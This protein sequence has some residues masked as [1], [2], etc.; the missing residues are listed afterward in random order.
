MKRLKRAAAVAAL[1]GLLTLS[2]GLAARADARG[3]V[4]PAATSVSLAEACS[5]LSEAIEFLEGRP[6]SRL[7]DFLLAQARRLFATYC[8]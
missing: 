4:E 3:A 7:R 5:A 1:G 2:P 8:A 6:Q